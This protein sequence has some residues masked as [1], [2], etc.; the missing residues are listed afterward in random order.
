LESGVPGWAPNRYQTFIEI[1][2]GAFADYT[3]K[4]IEGGINDEMRRH[5]PA[6]KTLDELY[7]EGKHKIIPNLITD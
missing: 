5:F 4:F 3:V 2:Q 1:E 7:D 6:K